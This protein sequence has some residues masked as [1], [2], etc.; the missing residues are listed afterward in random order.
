ML[1]CCV[2]VTDDVPLEVELNYVRSENISQID[3][4]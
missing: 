1:I 3:V 4:A 2:V